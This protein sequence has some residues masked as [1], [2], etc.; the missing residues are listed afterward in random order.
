MLLHERGTN[1]S[2]QYDIEVGLIS[3]ILESGDFLAVKEKQ[4]KPYF[5][6][7]GDN[8][9]AYRFINDYLSNS[10]RTLP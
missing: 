5:I 8:R 9:K 3:K 10:F 6:T 2:N 1:M 7:D 4:I